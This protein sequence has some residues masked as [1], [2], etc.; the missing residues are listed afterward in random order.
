[1][2]IVC[3]QVKIYRHLMFFFHN[4]RFFLKSSLCLANPVIVLGLCIC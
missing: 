1:M 2:K 3:A 4:I